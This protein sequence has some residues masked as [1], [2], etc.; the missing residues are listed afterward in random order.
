[1]TTILVIYEATDNDQLEAVARLL[2]E[3]RNGD[4]MHMLTTFTEFLEVQFDRGF[5]FVDDPCPDE[6]LRALR[7]AIDDA[8]PDGIVVTRY[9]VVVRPFPPM[10]RDTQI[11]VARSSF[12]DHMPR[13]PAS[14]PPDEEENEGEESEGED[15]PRGIS[16]WRVVMEPPLLAG[17]HRVA[18]PTPELADDSVAAP[19][20]S[21]LEIISQK[22]SD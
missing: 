3:A 22:P 5:L 19:R 16:Q 14:D 1:M 12:M 7:Q 6:D 20:Q 18:E 21:R 11:T 8:G 17:E 2:R 15:E 10:T 13:H 9:P 4:I